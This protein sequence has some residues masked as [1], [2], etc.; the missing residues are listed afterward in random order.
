MKLSKEYFISRDLSWLDFNSRV[1]EEATDKTNP[2]MERLKFVA[3]FA[4]NLDEFFMVRVA[5]L[6]H[7]KSGD[8]SVG[9][10]ELTACEH[11]AEIRRKVSDLVERQYACLNSEILPDLKKANTVI[12]KWAELSEAEK[13]ELGKYFQNQIFPALTPIAVDS[14]HPFPIINSGAIELAVK[15]K[16]SAS[17]KIV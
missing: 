15:L 9:S 16:Q 2:V 7:V 3:I 8:T 11:L 13:L 4:N 1:L 6:K 14:S 10:A 17:N 12:L 5:G